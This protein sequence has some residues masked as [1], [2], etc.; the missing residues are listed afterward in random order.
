MNPRNSADA[1]QTQAM[2]QHAAA[3]AIALVARPKWR[4]SPEP[5]TT[6]RPTDVTTVHPAKSSAMYREQAPCQ[7]KRIA[8]A[9]SDEPT[10][11]TR[12]MQMPRLDRKRVVSGKR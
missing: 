8:A 4:I 5:N 6:M 7:Q 1:S 3:A 11:A 12:A 10:A 2:V 9:R